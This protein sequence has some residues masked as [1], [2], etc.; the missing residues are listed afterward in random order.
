[1]RACH[2]NRSDL[3]RTT[4]WPAP[5]RKAGRYSAVLGRV[6]PRWRSLPP[7]LR[8]TDLLI[9]GVVAPSG[10]P[11]RSSLRR[12][13]FRVEVRSP[14]RRWGFFLSFI[15]APLAMIVAR[16]VG[17]SAHR[18]ARDAQAP[19]PV[20]R[21]RRGR[22]FSLSPRPSNVSEPFLVTA[23]CIHMLGRYVSGGR[24]AE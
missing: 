7:G 9:V 19:L 11:C 2:S 22:P 12:P 1:M 4:C 8:L 5:A 23:D 15:A 3:A 6:A 13:P 10:L 21:E 14:R 18:R 16:T 20:Q 17:A 24:R